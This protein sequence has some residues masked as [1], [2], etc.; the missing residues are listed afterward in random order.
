[1]N[2][3]DKFEEVMKRAAKEWLVNNPTKSPSFSMFGS[4]IFDDN[5]D[6]EEIGEYIIKA[7]EDAGYPVVSPFDVV[8]A[9]IGAENEQPTRN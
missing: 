5:E 8:R 6:A 2:S 7:A 4:M 3:S 9:L 1:M